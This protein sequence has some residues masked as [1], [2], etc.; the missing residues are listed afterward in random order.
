[1]QAL[2]GA[3]GLSGLRQGPVL[4]PGSFRR[5]PS[6]GAAFGPRNSRPRVA[7]AP[8]QPAIDVL[9]GPAAPHAVRRDP[10]AAK[11]ATRRPAKRSAPGGGVR[12]RPVLP[13]LEESLVLSEEQ[14]RAV[15]TVLRG[16]NLFLTGCAGTGK[17]VT[18]RALQR[19][20]LA[21]Y[22]N[23][24]DEYDR[25]V[26][27]VAM[28]GLAATLVGGVTLHSLLKLRTAD[29][30]EDLE[31]MAGGKEV[32]DRLFE[33]RTLIVDEAGM[34]S[35]ELLQALDCYLTRGRKNAAAQ[36]LRV[37]KPRA[38]EAEVHAAMAP[39]DKPFG[40]LQL[41][42]SGDFF[43][44]APIPRSSYRSPA[45]APAAAPREAL[46]GDYPFYNRGF[47][48]EAPVFQYG[49]FR[50]VELQKVFRQEDAAF[51]AL[52]NAVR[53]GDWKESSSALQQL[54][55]RCGRE[56]DAAD[57]IQPTLLFSRNDKVLDRNER[58]LRALG[59]REE[60]LTAADGVHVTHEPPS[61]VYE[62]LTKERLV[63]EE[64]FAR[65]AA[66]LDAG[67][68]AEATDRAVGAL[69]VGWGGGRAQTGTLARLPAA[70][71]HRAQEL[72]RRWGAAAQDHMRTVA[73][74]GGGLFR[75]CQ[76]AQKVSIKVGAQVMVV[77]N[78]DVREGIVNGSRGVVTGFQDAD[79]EDRERCVAA[80]D[81][82]EGGDEPRREVL[83][84]FKKNTRLPVV[85]LTS[86]KTHVVLP[87]V[88]TAAVPGY[89]LLVR[90]QCPLKLAWA[91]TVHKSQG[92]TL[93]KVDIDL[94]GFFGHG[95]LYTALSRS[96]GTEGLKL[97]NSAS[98]TVDSKV[99]AWW[100]AHRSGRRYVRPASERP[101]TPPLA[102][103]DPR[104]R[105][106]SQPQ[107]GGAARWWALGPE[108][109][110]DEARAQE[111]AE[112]ES[113]AR[114]L[115]E[116]RIQGV[117]AALAAQKAAQQEEAG[118]AGAGVGGVSGEGPVSRTLQLAEEA[119]AA[120]AALVVRKGSV[121]KGDLED[122][123]LP[124]LMELRS[125]LLAPPSPPP[126]QASG[127]GGSPAQAQGRG[128]GS[129][130]GQVVQMAE[131]ARGA[132]A[133]LLARPGAVKKSEV[134]GLL[135]LV[136]ALAGELRAAEGRTGGAA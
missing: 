129:G 95:M 89:G 118:E 128:Q 71:L 39:Y 17:S 19:T 40:G 30:T 41:I 117:A 77:W 126:P 33:L 85:K 14:Q 132:V 123:V 1:M 97:T 80:V 64:Q 134:E 52:L 37:I 51:V 25:R 113:E 31:R 94:D 67:A 10:L 36:R 119:R 81:K 108:A 74:G 96:R 116:I 79:D 53:C 35:A 2:N 48:F 131:A 45:S 104:H 69:G 125:L 88:F 27:V 47:M 99:L 22:G 120:L 110:E 46:E 90:V 9:R 24:R 50:I 58:E 133:G 93:D 103:L 11:P 87:A 65:L 4:A 21:K 59:G 124:L 32:L 28:T 63:S 34:M 15:N 121:R 66:E 61:S 106:L 72:R 84:W 86:G 109:Y 12:S 55:E 98:R 57:G 70:A 38:S 43:Q 107:S 105:H 8:Q 44:L 54:R 92:M 100:A 68:D 16:R 76:A 82:M 122:G 20:L 135:P 60:V 29:K 127:A 78:V 115:E 112:S 62:P 7:S 13:S 49:G 26:A 5:A 114:E 91:I 83:G 6:L 3:S 42:L 101:L 56:L 102:W 73:L 75:E 130:Q 18:L 136:E 111:A 23:S